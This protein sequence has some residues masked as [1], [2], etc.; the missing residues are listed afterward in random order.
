[1]GTMH[2]NAHGDTVG[3]FVDTAGR[4]HGFLAQWAAAQ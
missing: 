3:F 2:G 4:T 1:M